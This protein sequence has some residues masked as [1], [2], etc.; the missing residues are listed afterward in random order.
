MDDR[1]LGYPPSTWADDAWPV[2]PYPLGIPRRVEAEEQARQLAG[3]PRP[4]MVE[5]MH[6]MTRGDLDGLMEQD[7][8]EIAGMQAI[9]GS[10][11]MTRYLQ[12]KMIEAK[13]DFQRPLQQQ[14]PM[15]EQWRQY[16][17][18]RRQLEDEK[19]RFADAHACQQ[20]QRE[21]I[22]NAAMCCR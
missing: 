12:E 21:R 8:Q 13:A 4:R 16:R 6:S 10:I 20:E 17:E 19:I 18:E 7:R 3:L 2:K 5:V 22:H 9:E 1:K 15:D 14:A 11:A